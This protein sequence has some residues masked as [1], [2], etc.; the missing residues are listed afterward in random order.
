[1]ALKKRE[2]L[3]Y[4][5]IWVIL[6]L[7]PVVKL[8]EADDSVPGKIIWNELFRAWLS[9]IPLL[10][11]FLIHNHL[12]I[13]ILTRKGR[14]GKFLIYTW[15]LIM[16]F[17]ICVLTV[18]NRKDKPPRIGNTEIELWETRPAPPPPGDVTATSGRQIRPL[19]P[20][21][22]FFLTGLLIIGV[23]LVI[24]LIFKKIQDEQDARYLEKEELMGQLKYLKHQISPH[25]FMNTLNNIHALVDID[26]DKAKDSIVKL[27]NLMRYLLYEGDKPTI[28]L[29]KEVSF[30]NQYISLMKLRFKDSVKV[31]FSVPEMLPDVEVPAL[32]F[33]SFVENAFK[34]GVSY[35]HDSFIDVSLKLEGS[36]LLFN[37]SN[38]CH[39]NKASGEEGGIGISNSKKRLDLI[40]GNDYKLDI[41]DHG[42]MYTVDVDIPATYKS[43]A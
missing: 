34:H 38:S 26:P 9:I 41:I 13:P 42:E 29:E 15:I 31:S 33:I 43:I 30:L 40:Y 2:R 12:I 21:V 27:S 6:F 14:N 16:V 22:L 3:I 35:Q 39:E 7:I 1:M 25:F 24:A 18:V 36:R 32:L 5:I 10:L 19:P 28:P 23:N 8:F 20:E 17:G 37:C 4:L 11:L